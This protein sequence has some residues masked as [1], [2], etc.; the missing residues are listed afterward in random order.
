VFRNERDSRICFDLVSIV[1]AWGNSH[2]A[3]VHRGVRCVSIVL[4]PNWDKIRLLKTSSSAFRVLDI[5]RLCVLANPTSK[6]LPSRLSSF[7]TL[8]LWVKNRTVTDT[9]TCSSLHRIDSDV[10]LYVP[11]IF[12]CISK[13]IKEREQIFGNDDVYDEVNCRINISSFPFPSCLYTLFI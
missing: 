10:F 6:P 2:G 3:E 5:Q 7:T 4:P 13:S 12:T 11:L 1:G 9:G 8:T